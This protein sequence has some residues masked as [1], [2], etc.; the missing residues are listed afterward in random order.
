MTAI[1]NNSI[2]KAAVS[3]LMLLVLSVNFPV[4]AFADT[5]SVDIKA[6][7]QDSL[8]LTAGNSF[9]ISL[10][11][12]GATACQMT[13]PVTSGVATSMSTTIDPSHPW[14]PTAST[15]TTVSVTCTD[16]VSNISDSV[17]ISLG[18]PVVAAGPAA[19]VTVDISANSS[20]AGTVTIAP[21]SSYTYTWT[22]TN[23]TACQ[24]TSPAASGIATS[25]TSGTIAPGHPYYPTASTPTTL[26]IVCTDG[27][28]NATDSVVVAL[29]SAPAGGSSPVTVD[30]SVNN[31]T[32]GTVTI[33]PGSAYTYSW[34]STNATACQL[35]SPVASGIATSGTSGSIT[36]GHPYYPSAS[37]PTTFTI[38]CTDGVTNATDSVV[39]QL[40]AVVVSPAPV[41]VDIKANGQD[42]TVTLAPGTPYTYT[43]TSTNATACQL[44]SP[45]ASGIATSGTSG[46]IAPGH[47]YY[48]T[49]STPT[50]LTIVCTDGV[51]NATDSVVVALGSGVSGGPTPVTV[52]I[53]INGQDGTVSIVN[54]TPYTYSWTSTNATACQL[55]SPV[56]SGIATTGVS[57]SITPGHAYYPAV[58][59]STT[60]TIVCTDGV[61][62]ATDSVVVTV[63]SPSN[64]G[65][66]CT[67]NCGGGSSVPPTG[68]SSVPPVN[69]GAAC[70]YVRDYMRADFQN[71]PTEVAK[72]QAFLKVYE[73]HQEVSVNGV[74]DQ[75][76]INAV[77]Q[78]QVKYRSDILDPWALKGPTGYVYI[79]SL[80]KINELY[81]L[82]TFPLNQA[83]AN[84][85]VAF[86]DLVS[87]LRAQGINVVLPGTT[88]LVAVQHTRVVADSNGQIIKTATTTVTIPSV[89]IATTTD[90]GQNQSKLA[91][92]LTTFPSTLMNGLQCLYEFL[93][94]LIV[95]YILASVLE[96]V[97]YKKEDITTFKKRFF[98]KWITIIVGLIV[99]IIIAYILNELC[100]ILPLLI[101]LVI[102]LIWTALYPK[103]SSITG[104]AKAWYLVTTARAKNTAA[105]S[106][107]TTTVVEKK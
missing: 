50:T 94:I 42:G 8:T 41:T 48:P 19:P 57:G 102:S 10:S 92:A 64:P 96:D 91:A 52:D 69:P 76:T 71:D 62:N 107:T 73:G 75:A 14:Y 25:G 37:T 88:V 100:L 38:V 43:W 63:T 23:A 34:T 59:G 101:A 98:T 20:A 32:A 49:A 87:G 85:I 17:I 3:I 2:T 99:A 22:S 58:G 39:V 11:A 33:A 31:S 27:V 16:G 30:I 95:L 54:G 84:E 51:T 53:K 5:F 83:Q 79:L 61:S 105:D 40:G 60:F 66:G 26:T 55:T 28:T 93:L 103:H 70:L 36:S 77:N 12:P 106:T 46:T 65:G 45:A 67:S 81:C 7:N 9:T 13:S 15:P 82:H 18:S 68:G 86:H 72:L 104:S 90:K 35:T 56:A 47:P 4:Q 6:D 1:R 74:Y 89:G 78:F 80:K 21:G 24:L 44:T 29:G 97:L